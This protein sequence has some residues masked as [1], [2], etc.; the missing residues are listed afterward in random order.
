[1]NNVPDAQK[2]ESSSHVSRREFLASLTTATA[3][4]AF[5]AV[6]VPTAIAAPAD[7]PPAPPG[8]QYMP[9]GNG[10]YELY[11]IED[12]KKIVVARLARDGLLPRFLGGTYVGETSGGFT[13]F[14]PKIAGT[15]NVLLAPDTEVEAAGERRISDL[16]LIKVGDTVN[17]GTTLDS[18]GQRI[19]EYVRANVMIGFVQVVAV[20]SGGFTGILVDKGLNPFPDAVP[21]EFTVKQPFMDTPSPAPALGEYWHYFATS[22]SPS[23]PQAIWTHTLMRVGAAR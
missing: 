2:P 18:N 14:V 15:I 20:G 3:G 5:A 7:T 8:T 10:A 9:I 17:V 6:G 19:A 12:G 21:M 23:Q 11:R 1:M 4:V 13:V 16:S 22:S